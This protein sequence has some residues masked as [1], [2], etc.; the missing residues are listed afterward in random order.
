VVRE[1]ARHVQLG[2]F[3]IAIAFGLDYLATPVGT[4]GALTAIEQG[5]V[6]LW[7]WGATITAA[8]IVGLLVEWRILGDDHP[9]LVTDTRWRWGW[10]TNTA[11]AVLCGLFAA[12]AGSSLWDVVERGLQQGTWYG[13]R[14]GL[15]W[16]GYAALNWA[17]VPRTR[18]IR[19]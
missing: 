4:S 17:F 11:H 19:A 9:I 16:G 6:P 8:G 2:V 10:A 3:V 1:F 13:W 15:L 5:V 18:G 12:L 14:T 7:C